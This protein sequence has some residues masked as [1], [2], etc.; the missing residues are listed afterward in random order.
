LD[1]I[2]F[3]ESSGELLSS[4]EDSFGLYT[5]LDLEVCVGDMIWNLLDMAGAEKG[6]FMGLPPAGGG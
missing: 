5:G 6:N 4:G 1:W 2:L 3:K